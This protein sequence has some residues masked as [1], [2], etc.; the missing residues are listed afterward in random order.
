MGIMIKKV[1]FLFALGVLFLVLCFKFFD[2]SGTLSHYENINYWYLPLFFLA[3][4]F[5][6]YLRG[7][8][9]SY[10]LKKLVP[11]RRKEV[12][13]TYMMGSM[14]D[15]LIPVRLSEIIKCNYIKK[16]YGLSISKVLPTVFIDKLFDVSPILVV[17]LTMPFL[18]YT[19]SQEIYYVVYF[20]LAM[21]IV[22]V[23]F[24]VFVS[25]NVKLVMRLRRRFIN[26]K[27]RKILGLFLRFV[28]G[29]RK[30]NFSLALFLKMFALSLL[31]I[32]FNCV[33]FYVCILALGQSLP[34]VMV[35]FGYALL[36]LSYAA[37]SP[38]GQMGSNEIVALFIFSGMFGLPANM[39]AAI[40]IFAHALIVF[41]IVGIGLIVLKTFKKELVLALGF[42][43]EKAKS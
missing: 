36:F 38:P 17:L 37:P 18:D 42:F 40:I 2:L 7:T 11:I 29:F 35:L 25:F 26:K 14:I 33:A 6:T 43:G 20:L 23:G 27:V 19:F 12:L 28:V 3:S 4:G 5:T 24:L 21:L 39:V 32:F 31:A 22:G 13:Q 8:R 15:F 30:L 16:Q 41:Y 10:L 9:W 34:F 1:L